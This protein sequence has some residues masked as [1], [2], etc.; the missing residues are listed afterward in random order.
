MCLLAALLISASVTIR[1][2]QRWLY[3]PFV[4]CVTYLSHLA[5]RLRLPQRAKLV[6]LAV[7]TLCVLGLDFY[8]LRFADNVFFIS[9]Q[10]YAESLYDATVGRFGAEM[11]DYSIYIADAQPE[12]RWFLQ[13]TLFLTPYLGRDYQRIA[14]VADAQDVAA[15]PQLDRTHTLVFKRDSATRSYVDVTAEVLGDE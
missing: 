12:D 5:S 9:G 1:Q 11:R 3:A 8:Y 13:E 2:E 14:Y 15:L 7:L 10:H 6:G 4:V